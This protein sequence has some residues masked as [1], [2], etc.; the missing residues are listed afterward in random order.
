MPLALRGCGIQDYCREAGVRNLKKHIEKIYRKCALRLVHAGAKGP[1]QLMEEQKKEKEADEADEGDGEKTG[2]AEV[3][4]ESTS[5][6]S[7]EKATE[8]P[9]PEMPAAEY[10]GD[11]IVVTP[12]C[13]H[14]LVGVAPFKS[15]RIFDV[16]PPGVV[17]GLAW[18]AMGGSTLYTEAA[19]AEQSEGKVSKAARYLKP[20]SIQNALGWTQE[21]RKH[22]RC[23][24]RKLHPCS[25]LRQELSVGKVIDS[26][27]ICLSPAALCLWPGIQGMPSSEM[28]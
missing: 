15:D 10:T 21:Y 24:E 18:T 28:P 14:D 26:C 9:E 1:K 5:D 8:Q 25:H 23:H 4:E 12:T 22:W 27:S 17:M 20:C 13:L 7:E 2:E 16:M 19:V 11:P 3:K 6:K